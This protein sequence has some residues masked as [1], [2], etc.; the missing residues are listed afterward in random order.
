VT[1]AAGGLATGQLGGFVFC[2]QGSATY[3]W[4]FRG[5]GF[6]L[7]STSFETAT[8][9]CAGFDYLSVESGNPLNFVCIYCPFGSSTVSS[10][11]P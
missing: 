11:T 9:K 7:N 1:Q 10:S 6:T 2:A 4:D 5:V 3:T 8:D